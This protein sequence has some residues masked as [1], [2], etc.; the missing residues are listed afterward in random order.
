MENDSKKKRIL[1]IDDEPIII[2]ISEKVLTGEGL[3]WMWLVMVWLP[4]K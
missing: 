4:K 3:K 1:A 2:R